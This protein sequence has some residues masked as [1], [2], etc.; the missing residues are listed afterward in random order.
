VAEKGHVREFHSSLSAVGGDFVAVEFCLLQLADTGK[1]DHQLI[2]RFHLSHRKLTL[3]I[4]MYN[5]TT[6]QPLLAEISLMEIG[7]CGTLRQQFQ[8]Y[9]KQLEFG[10]NA[11]LPDHF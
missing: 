3:N 1:L 8:E 4:Y 5:V 6:T 7:A 10:K 11:E 2:R 9:L